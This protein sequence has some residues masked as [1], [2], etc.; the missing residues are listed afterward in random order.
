[1]GHRAEVLVIKP[2]SL[3]AEVFG[4]E[5]GHPSFQ[6]GFWYWIVPERMKVNAAYGIALELRLVVIGFLWD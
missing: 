3:F 5:Q 6:F 1:M 4:Q 2:L